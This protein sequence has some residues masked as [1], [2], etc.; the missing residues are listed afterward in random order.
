MRLNTVFK[1]SCWILCLILLS[2]TC[3]AATQTETVIRDK[4][5]SG[6]KTNV[7]KTGPVYGLDV[8]TQKR[9][10]ICNKDDDATPNYYG[11]EATDGSWIIMKET[12]S[13]GA[14]VYAYESGT[15]GYS[16]GWTNRATTNTYQSF[17]TEF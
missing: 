11:F 4:T 5:N 17:G 12:V 15:S 6:T 13:A 3:F 2:S 16:T 10:M 7:E 9:Y 1:K 14:D 8:A